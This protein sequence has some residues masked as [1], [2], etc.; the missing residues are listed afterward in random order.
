[1]SDRSKPIPIVPTTIAASVESFYRSALNAILNA[2]LSGKK[3]SLFPN[4]HIQIPTRILYINGIKNL[5]HYLENNIKAEQFPS[6]NPTTFKLGLACMPGVIMT[7]MSSILEASNAGHMNPAPI[8]TRWISGLV[9]R[10]LRE[11]IFAVGL[12]QLSDW[13]EDKIPKSVTENRTARNAA[14][15]LIAGVLSGYL[16]HVP[17]NLSTLKL[18]TPSKT[19]QQHFQSLVETSEKRLPETLSPSVRRNLGTVGVFLFPK[20]VHIRTTQIVGSFV[21]LN[22]I[23]KALQD[24]DF[25]K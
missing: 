25:K 16:S 1:M 12:N 17:H 2:R 18:M 7:P 14:G 15:S 8:Y 22:G 23:I 9:P 6:V 21:L 5:R 4:M 13:C 11:V 10:T 19:Y 3:A 24:F 20:G